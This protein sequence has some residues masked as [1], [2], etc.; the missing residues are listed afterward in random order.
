MRVLHALMLAA[1]AFSGRVS[2]EAVWLLADLCSL[3]TA[4]PNLLCCFLLR[5]EVLTELQ[6]ASEHRAQQLPQGLAHRP[7]RVRERRQI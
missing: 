4:A 3:L 1:I 7:R 5:R 6:S 2:L